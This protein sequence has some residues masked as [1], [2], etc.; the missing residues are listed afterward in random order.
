MCFPENGQEGIVKY[1]SIAVC[2]EGQVLEAADAVIHRHMNLPRSAFQPPDTDF[3]PLHS[4][5]LGGDDVE[6]RFQRHLSRKGLTIPN[7]GNTIDFRRAILRRGHTHRCKQFAVNFRTIC[8][9][10]Q[11]SALDRG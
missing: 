5:G 3:L 2:M 6:T 7:S 11:Q 4:G 10:E 9:R 1:G 8:T